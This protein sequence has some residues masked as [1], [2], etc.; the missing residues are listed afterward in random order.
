M[1]L[2]SAERSRLYRQR[3]K[4]NPEKYSEYLMKER[5][6][7][8][9]R[10]ESGDIKPISEMNSRQQRNTRREWKKRKQHER[11]RKKMVTPLIN[12]TPPT[13]PTEGSPGPFPINLRPPSQKKLSGRKRVRRER[14]KSYRR[15][16]AL[17]EKL[18][19]ANKRAERYRKQLQRCKRTVD[20]DSPRTKTRLLLKGQ[21]VNKTTRK[22]LLFHHVFLAGIRQKYREIK[23][24]KEKQLLSNAI[25]SKLL[26]KYR[27]QQQ[28]RAAL[29]TTNRQITSCKREKPHRRHTI[30]DKLRSEVVGFLCRD[31]NSRVKPGKKS[32]KTV[33][34]EKK[35]IRLLSDSLKN[36][37]SKFLSESV[38]R[39]ISYSFFCRL[40][41][42]YIRHPTL[43]DRETCLCK[44]HENLKFK[45]MKLKQSSLISSQDLHELAKTVV[46]DTKNKSCMYR[47]CV[48]CKERKVPVNNFETGKMTEWYE[49][50]TERIIKTKDSTSESK[51][52][53]MTVKV[54]EKGTISQ[55]V[56]EFQDELQKC[57]KHLYNITHQY[58]AIRSLKENLS[59]TDVILHVDFSENYNC[60]YESEIQ[61]THFGAS[62]K[63]VSIHTGVLYT[64][65]STDGFCSISDCLKHGPSGIW[66]H[67]IPVLKYARER[68]QD[69]RNVFFISDGPTTQYRC[70]DNFFLLS[71]IPFELGY[72]SVNWSFMEAG[73]GKGAPDG[74][75][76]VVKREADRAVLHG[77][78]I[79]SAKCLHD[80]L[81]SSDVSLKIF[82]VTEEDVS[83]QQDVIPH[84]LKAVP[85][86]MKIHQVCY[87][88]FFTSNFLQ[89]QFF[90]LFHSFLHNKYKLY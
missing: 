23:S 38:K 76:A 12:I 58:Q 35:Q 26:K 19:S 36:L 63:Q 52:V 20:V 79:S 28:A 17:E 75:G 74:I 70:K 78:D 73:H 1:P 87:K 47:Q 71:K 90:I 18:K 31:D 9:H 39:K 56:N 10:K 22:V 8:K 89:T 64:S 72:S 44:K 62:Q 4:E 14:S 11:E 67:L 88:I 60:K 42:F 45:S 30:L 24:N 68:N 34:K 83:L 77:R 16:Q 54:K 55:L 57:C 41:P 15:I 33:Q 81:V 43:A 46:C 69:L 40:K 49:W 53:S 13:S 3:L 65:K 50:K 21:K 5:T 59:N 32:T 85:G 37:Y 86:T 66:A 7:Y 51:I 61:S 6:R 84:D 29:D 48:V 27:M 2:T 82:T 80:V 25:K